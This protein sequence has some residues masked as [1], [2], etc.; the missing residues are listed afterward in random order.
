MN[1]ISH[2]AVLIFHPQ[3]IRRIFFRY[4]YRYQ[5]VFTAKVDKRF[6]SIIMHNSIKSV[7][8]SLFDFTLCSS[9][10]DSQQYSE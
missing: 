7:C 3:I 8:V 5:F 10:N 9:K 4:R 6:A 1:F 2:D